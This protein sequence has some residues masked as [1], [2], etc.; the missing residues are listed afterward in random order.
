MGSPSSPLA[1]TGLR[2]AS[3]EA[4]FVWCLPDGL[5]HRAQ[6]PQ[7]PYPLD[8]Q[9]LAHA[10]HGIALLNWEDTPHGTHVGLPAL[11]P[12]NIRSLH[13]SAF[14]LVQAP[15][16]LR[17]LMR[18]Q[19]WKWPQWPTSAPSGSTNPVSPNALR[20]IFLI[21]W[22]IIDESLSQ[23]QVTNLASATLSALP[24]PSSARRTIGIPMAS[25]LSRLP[26]R[27]V[28]PGVMSLFFDAHQSG[29]TDTLSLVMPARNPPILFR[30]F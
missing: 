26:L 8:L 1:R 30:G 20:S 4:T 24:V 18:Q 10:W 23:V 16:Q 29:N 21:D 11:L 25:M 15:A 28:I 12:P 17:T 9:L 6:P 14:S 22:P 5:P 13:G 7:I 27:L 2:R 19:S 3:I